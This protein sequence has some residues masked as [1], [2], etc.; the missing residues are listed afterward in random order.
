MTKKRLSAIPKADSAK[1]RGDGMFRGSAAAM[2]TML[3]CL[4]Y[5]G[6]SRRIG[7][8]RR[9]ELFPA[10]LRAE[11]VDM[12]LIGGRLGG[13]RIDTPPAD[14]VDILAGLLPRIVTRS[15]VPV[16]RI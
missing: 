6:C 16:I 12:S 13:R 14:W 8:R 3:L 11:I 2:M 7:S 10:I 5:G 1:A 15:I 9:F 4:R